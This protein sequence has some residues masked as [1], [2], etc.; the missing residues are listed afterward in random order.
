MVVDKNLEK[1]ALKVELSSCLK[2][3]IQ[4]NSGTESTLNL[5]STLI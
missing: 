4:I 1:S 3:E 2:Y 5:K